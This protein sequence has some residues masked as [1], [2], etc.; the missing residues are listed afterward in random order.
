VNGWQRAAL[1]LALLP[2]LLGTLVFLAWLSTDWT[3]LVFVGLLV[4]NF[5]L[6]A[7]VVVAI[8]LVQGH[9][10]AARAGVARSV[11]RRRTLG[12][13]LVML[14]NYPVAAGMMVVGEQLITRWSVTIENDAETPWSGVELQWPGGQHLVEVLAPG[15]QTDVSLWILHDGVVTLGWQ[16][17]AGREHRTVLDYVTPGWGGQVELVRRGAG[18]VR[19]AVRERR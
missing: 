2:L 14:A 8:L 1:A 13:A 3:P 12:I 18:D 19:M 17:A 11:R 9:R 4:H 5:G 15:A 6:V 16:E 10:H 7:T